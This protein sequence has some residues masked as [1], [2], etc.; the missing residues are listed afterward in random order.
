VVFNVER[1]TNFQEVSLVVQE[2]NQLQLLWFL[3][4]LLVAGSNQLERP[5]L[6]SDL[7]GLALE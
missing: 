7:F 1:K 2:L 6:E 4:F 5:E 3:C